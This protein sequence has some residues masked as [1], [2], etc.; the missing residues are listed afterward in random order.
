MGDFHAKKRRELGE[1]R[2][3]APENHYFFLAT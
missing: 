1:E 2:Q 3:K